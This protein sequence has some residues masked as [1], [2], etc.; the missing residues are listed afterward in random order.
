MTPKHFVGLAAAAVAS[1]VAALLVYS[2][3]VPWSRATL[4]GE[5]LFKSLQGTPPQIARI[6]ILQGSN[7]LTL[8]RNGKDWVLEE[9]DGFPATPEKVRAFLVSLSDAKLV[10]PKTRRRERYGLLG[11]GD[12][13][14]KGAT[15]RL[16][17]LI[18]NN[19][20]TVAEAVIGKG[21]SDAF[22]SGKGGT[23]VR[24]LGDVQTWLVSTE[25]DTG[26]TLRDWVKQRLFE[27]RPRDV[28]SITV[29]NPGKED[30]KIALAADG[31]GHELQD[32]PAGMKIKYINSIDDLADAASSFDFDDVKKLD[33]PPAD[34]KVSTVTLLLA[35]GLKCDFKIRRDGGVAW[36]T[37]DA[38][39]E[40]N[41][42]K[43][44]DELMAR[45]KGWEF[46]IPKSK[47][48]AILKTR[49]ELLE[50]AS[51]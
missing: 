26:V 33:A 46:R 7:Q 31:N 29:R 45:A 43:E 12:P 50:K 5:P 40:D 35:N 13:H 47:A 28:K 32:I 1:V 49:E 39:G 21:R 3:S 37:L 44:A 11:L 15:S 48:D 16:V 23:Y 10:E 42:K 22:G 6:E 51:S 30:L 34:D 27:A 24:R 18:D 41:A 4:N 2:S 17:R 36:V 19:G 8:K 20:Q 25:I 38:S 9:R 14:D